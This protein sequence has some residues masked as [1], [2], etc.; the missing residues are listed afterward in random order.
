MPLQMVKAGY[1]FIRTRSNQEHG[2]QITKKAE[3]TFVSPLDN[4]MEFRY[5]IKSYR[6]ISLRSHFY[7]FQLFF[8]GF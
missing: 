3:N 8:S 1:S 4:Y 7:C 5:L 6:A 2:V